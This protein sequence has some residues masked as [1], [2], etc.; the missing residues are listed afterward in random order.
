ESNGAGDLAR[1]VLE[2]RPLLIELDPL[3]V[4]RLAK[5]FAIYRLTSEQMARAALYKLAG[6]AIEMACWDLVG[7]ILNKRC[8]DLWGGIEKEQVEFA[9]YVFYRYKSLEDE[10]NYSD[11]QYVAEYTLELLET[12]G[13][14]DVKFKNGVLD[15]LAEV[16]TVR[17]MRATAGSRL[18]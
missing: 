10:G 1:A 17:R 11:P 2:C 18:R 16:D 13:F 4:S 3:E 7:K 12:H 5:R 6:A 9:A 8:G 14:R 15:P